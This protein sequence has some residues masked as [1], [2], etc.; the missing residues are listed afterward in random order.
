MGDEVITLQIGKYSNR[1]GF[2]FWEEYNSQ[3]NYAADEQLRADYEEGK[4]IDDKLL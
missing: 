1:I 2:E 4:E 3:W